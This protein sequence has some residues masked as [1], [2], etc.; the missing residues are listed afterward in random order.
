[1]IYDNDG[2]FVRTSANGTHTTGNSIP[3]PRFGM[4]SPLDGLTQ[5]VLPSGLTRTTTQTREI[6][7]ASWH[8]NDGLDAIEA[9]YLRRHEL[10]L[11]RQR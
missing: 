7:P 8:I 11:L 9:I 4:Q 6:Y 2:S 10:R 3:D 5:T 1:L